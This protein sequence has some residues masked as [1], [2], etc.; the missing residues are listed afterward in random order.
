MALLS[1]VV[2]WLFDCSKACSVVVVPRWRRLDIAVAIDAW[3]IPGLNRNGMRSL[4]SQR[5]DAS[6]R[7]SWMRRILHLWHQE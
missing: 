2:R 3:P 1:R 4:E 6:R 7:R 5:Q